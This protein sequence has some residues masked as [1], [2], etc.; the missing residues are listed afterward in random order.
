MGTGCGDEIIAAGGQAIPLLAD[1]A[2]QADLEGAVATIEQAWARL[3]SVVSART[4]GVWAP[5]DDLTLEEWNHTSTTNLTRTF[6]TTRAS[7]PLL[8]KQGGAIVITVS[9]NGT[10]IFSNTGA[11]AY[12]S[13]KAA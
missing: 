2:L 8:R 6:L 13:S 11:I 3:D 12:S 10:R 7:V 1:V 9:V 5:I 4:N